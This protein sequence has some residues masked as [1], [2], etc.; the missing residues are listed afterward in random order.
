MCLD[1]KLSRGREREVVKQSLIAKS[2]TKG[3]LGKT[4]QRINEGFD[5]AQHITQHISALSD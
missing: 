5:E 2:Q 1:I 4:A 3:K